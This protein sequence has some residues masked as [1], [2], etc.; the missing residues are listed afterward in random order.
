[1]AKDL[2]TSRIDR[3]N[4]LNNDIALAE[5]QEKTDCRGILWEGKLF[6]TKE[7]VATFFE[8]DIRTI[9]RYLSEYSDELKSNGYEV[10]RGERLREFLT[11]MSGTDMNVGVKIN[12]LGIFDF[13]AFLDLA[14]LLSES[15]KARILRQMMLDIVIDLIN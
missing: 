12:L 14:M 9:E 2:T 10:L 6:F 13:R 4:I 7:I 5:I 3:Q 15:E 8:V 11:T 1:M